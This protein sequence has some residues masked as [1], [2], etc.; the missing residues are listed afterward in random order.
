MKAGNKVNLLLTSKK[1]QLLSVVSFFLFTSHFITVGNYSYLYY[2]VVGVPHGNPILGLIKYLR[3]P[4]CVF[5][6]FLLLHWLRVRSTAWT[7]LVQ[8]VDVLI[9]S[10]ILILGLFNTFDLL[11]GLLYTFW[12]IF[13][14]VL[15]LSYCYY[16]SKKTAY[17]LR[18]R[19]LL[20]LLFY[21]NL[22]ILFFLLINLHTLG[23]D[24]K[25]YMAFTSKTFFAYCLFVLFASLAL[26]RI[27][28]QD[29]LVT[30]KSNFS[31]KIVDLIVAVLVLT[32]G[33]LS[34][35]RSVILSMAIVSVAFIYYAVGK[36]LWKKLLLITVTAIALAIFVPVL[37]EYADQN[38]QS[39]AILSKIADA[40]NAI[41]GERSDGSFNERVIVWS[42]YQRLSE[43]YPLLGTGAYNGEVLLKHHFGDNYYTNISTHNTFLSV[44]VEHGWLGLL[45]FISI[46]IRSVWILVKK[47][48]RFVWMNYLIVLVVPV[49]FINYFEFN[50][51][52]GQIFYWPTFLVLLFPR[53]LLLNTVSVD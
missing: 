8:N 33:V 50:L 34:A 7:F 29:S 48:T 16:L 53:A 5:S 2:D 24:V 19:D 31:G 42:F 21:S 52:P 41:E 36:R 28:Y 18:L 4:I 10:I 27:V 25:Y 15:I 17:S 40:S 39:L 14:L 6:A 3:L 13:S 23:S 46:C 11:N 20:R 47:T 38:R 37:L 12:Q 44:L 35:R 45:A 30:G 49:I 22:I 51:Y 9:F 1:V 32:F 43:L 26:N